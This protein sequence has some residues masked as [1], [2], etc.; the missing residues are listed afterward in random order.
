MLCVSYITNAPVLYR[1]QNMRSDLR[2]FRLRL[3]RVCIF[4]FH[5][6]SL[7][8]GAVDRKTNE[9]YDFDIEK[10]GFIRYKTLKRSF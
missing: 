7:N 8:T 1:V 3:D 4:F 9:V 6:I 5:E 2:F 10:E